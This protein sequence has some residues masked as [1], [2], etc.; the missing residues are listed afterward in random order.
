MKEIMK[1][2]MKD[3]INNYLYKDVTNV[4]IDYLFLEMNEQID[5]KLWIGLQDFNKE[6]NCWY[7]FHYQ[8]CMKQ[9]KSFLDMFYNLSKQSNK[10]EVVKDCIN[11]LCAAICGIKKE[12]DIDVEEDVDEEENLVN[13]LSKIEENVLHTIFDF[14][15]QH[16]VLLEEKGVEYSY[17]EF[18]IETDS[19]FKEKALSV[20][21]T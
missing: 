1:E 12:K 6:N 4:I 18:L 2:I 14:A 10:K 20:F 13:Q 15:I 17:V 21:N 3:K 19:L 11:S 16:S 5:K 7:A 8:E 9:S